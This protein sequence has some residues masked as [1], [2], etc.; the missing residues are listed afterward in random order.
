[1][2]LELFDLTGKAAVVTG[3]GRGLGRVLA[4]GLAAAGARVVTCARTLSEVEATAREIGEAGGEAFA[5]R[6]DITDRADCQALV[7][8]TVARFGTLDVMVCNAAYGVLQPAET[9]EPEAWDQTLRVGL[10]GTF[11]CAQLAGRQMMKQTTGGSIVVT[12]STSS[13]VAFPGL[14]AYD[15]AKGG[16]D[17]LVRT[18]AVEWASKGIR[19]NAFNPGYTENVMTDIVGEREDPWVQLAIE[20]MTPMGRVGR[21]AEFVGPVIFLASDASSFVTGVCLPVDGGYCAL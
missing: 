6:V 18:L 15:A 19:V 3:S 1:M 7:D 16:V 8:A 20:K 10:T 12:S 13:M 17:Q 2:S 11:N 9:T 14:V 4:K 5:L 21:L